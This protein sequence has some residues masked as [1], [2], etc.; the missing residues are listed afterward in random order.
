MQHTKTSPMNQD[1]KEKSKICSHCGKPLHG[2]SDQVYCNDTCRNTFNR[3]KRA[4]EKITEHENM[5]EI[6]RIIKRN[7]EILKRWNRPFEQNESGFTNT[8]NLI[9]DG[10]NPKFFTS[11]IKDEYGREWRCIFER[12]FSVDSELTEIRDFPKQAEI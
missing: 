9:A 4:A 10:F 8:K 1:L 12:G 6:I 2:R 11:I 3:Q 5:P 7:Y